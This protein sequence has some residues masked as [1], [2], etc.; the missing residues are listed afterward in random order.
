MDC[1]PK[2]S[3]LNTF[4]WNAQSIRPKSTSFEQ[5]LIQEK[6]HIA[7]LCE[8]WLEKE[9]N[10]NIT[11][12]NIFRLDRQDGYG[13]VAIFAHISI[14][15]H[16]CNTYQSNPGIETLHIK[17]SNC[18]SVEN[19]IAV[20]CPSNI[21]TCPRDWDSI[22]SITSRKTLILG[23]FNGHHTNWSC[24]NDQR[25]LQIFD[26]VVENNYI[27]VNNGAVTRMKLVNGSFQRS[28]P[29]I[30]FVTL[31]LGLN[32]TWRVLNESL[33]SDHLMI[34]ITIQYNEIS[35]NIKK[36]NFKMS[37]WSKFKATIDNILNKSSILSEP[38]ACYDFLINTLQ[39]SADCHIPFKILLQRIATKFKPKAF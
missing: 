38:Q 21:R 39:K 19:I 4:Q 33:G 6:V 14:T 28:S 1:N 23:D 5:L 37:D 31:D 3:S 34:K 13:G 9:S 16:I 8:T 36:R 35:S 18:E 11:G 20:Y 25:R 15:A 32:C 27:S 26:S 10:F 7:V 17:I 2:S 30:S 29:D 24:K 22:F 12:Y